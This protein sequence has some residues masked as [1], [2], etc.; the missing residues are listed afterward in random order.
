MFYASFQNLGIT[1]NCTR[2]INI[3]VVDLISMH[4]SLICSSFLSRDLLP[5]SPE[6]L[7]KE[8]QFLH[9]S[10]KG[11]ITQ[12]LHFFV[13]YINAS[14]TQRNRTGGELQFLI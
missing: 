2:N 12:Y 4:F 3:L 8:L 5:V 10:R 11:G 1:D 6:L 9:E 13:K 14:N 7:K